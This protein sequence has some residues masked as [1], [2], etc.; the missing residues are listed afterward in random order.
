[1]IVLIGALWLPAAQPRNSTE[2]MKLFVAAF[3][4]CS[5]LACYC[6]TPVV[7]SPGWLVLN[8]NT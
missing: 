3:L 5:S 2:L 8:T 7:L 4:L 1:M 6:H